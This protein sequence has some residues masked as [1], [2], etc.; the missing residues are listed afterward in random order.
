MRLIH[1]SDWHLGRIFYNV[2]LTDDQ[3]HVLDQFV[4]LVRDEAPDAVLI[5]GDIYDRAVPPPEAVSLLD[6]TL[7]RIALDLKV[8][9]IMIAGN[10]DSPER[11]SF[12]SRLLS[13]AQVYTFGEVARGVN[14]NHVTLT[15]RHGDIDVFAV[16]YAEPPVVRHYFEDSQV[17][18]HQSAF[19]TL[20]DHIRE[21]KDA[22]GK[23]QNRSVLMTHAFV[24]GGQESDSERPLSVGGSGAI[25]ADLFDGFDY[26]ALGHLH[27]P[28]KVSQESIQYSGSLLKYSFSEANQKKAINII[29]MDAE[30]RISV[31]R[32]SLSPRRDLRRIS[33]TLHELMQSAEKDGSKDD[34][35]CAELTDVGA[36][37]DAPGQLRQFYPNLM[38]IE[39][40]YI[41]VDRNG[42]ARVD[43][44]ALSDMQLFSQ[45]FAQ[46]TGNELTEDQANA[47]AGIMDDVRRSQ[48]QGAL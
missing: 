20:I 34:Y 48:R 40:P 7:C 5:A 18:D 3:A 9:V 15:D 38:Q 1:T 35:I 27:R 21:H 37:F 47:Y 43:H 22:P 14:A 32:Q 39:R 13:R 4:D 44:R 12:G 41:A 29:D 28:Q 30:G 23:K 26:V 45:F 8:P 46:V 24:S 36:L 19:Q 10:H 31:R 2:H 16:P 33:G 25:S 42:D 11:V 17:A 6:E